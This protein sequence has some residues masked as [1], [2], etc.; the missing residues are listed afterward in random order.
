MSGSGKGEAGGRAARHRKAA[1]PVLFIQ[2]VAANIIVAGTVTLLL[3]LTFETLTEDYFHR[4]MVEFNISPTKLNSMFVEDVEKSLLWGIGLSL[5]I[6]MILSF[7][8]TK[9]VLRPLSRM[10][11]VS[12]KIS[13]GDYSARAPA[14]RGE[15][16]TLAWHF[17]A[18]AG[19][20][21]RQDKARRQMLRD[22]SHELRTPLTNLKGYIEGLEDGVF[23]LDASVIK[24]LTDEV[25]T[26]NAL[27]DDLVLL[28][29][30]EE[31]ESDLDLEEVD[32]AAELKSVL[33]AHKHAI[34]EKGIRLSIRTAGVP[35]PVLADRKRLHQVLSNAVANLIRYST[36]PASGEGQNTEAA[37]L[38]EW[39]ADGPVRVCFENPSE[40]ISPAQ[41]ELLFDR[42]YRVDPSR[43]GKSRNAGL[44]LAIVK[45]LVQAQGGETWAEQADG[46]FR[47]WISLTPARRHRP[48]GAA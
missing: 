19:T 29:T 13:A 27:I 28:G 26:I 38:I 34:L 22:L 48:S 24:V 17:N 42:F 8:L 6:G 20:L 32:L 23:E 31:I 37:I 1:F 9:A 12:E 33:D 45:R 30:A 21:E 5:A 2:L 43:S 11:E 40:A 35:S 15:L 18:M 16:G 7:L 14:V 4:L 10:A 25:Q 41:L 36:A 39:P 46:L 47:L 44:G 3:Y